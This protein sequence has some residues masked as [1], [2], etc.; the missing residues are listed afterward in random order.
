MVTNIVNIIGFLFS[1][2]Y[3][4]EN[5]ANI[6]F[7]LSTWTQA[8]RIREKSLQELDRNDFLSI[9]VD[10][11]SRKHSHI[12]QTAH[13]IQIAL[14][15]GHKE[16]DS[17][18]TR[19]CLGKG[20]DL[21]VMQKIH[22]FIADLIKIIFPLDRHRR[23]FHPVSILP[24]ASGRTYLTKIDFRIKVGC[25]CISVVSSIAVQNINGIDL[26]KLML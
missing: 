1:I 21:L 14:S 16:T 17:L 5:A 24:V 4:G 7:S 23:N 11:S 12:L 20:L 8:G 19:N 22:I 13:V 9:I 18:Y 25:K 15:E 3:P 2:L 10:R 26:V 6:S